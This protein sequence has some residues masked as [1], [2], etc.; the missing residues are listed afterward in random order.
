[1]TPAT[2]VAHSPP[3]VSPASRHGESGVSTRHS[4]GNHRT[5]IAGWVQ[6][7]SHMAA[8]CAEPAITTP[9]HRTASRTQDRR[10]P[11]TSALAAALTYGSPRSTGGGAVAAVIPAGLAA[12]PG[13]SVMQPAPASWRGC[14]HHSAGVA[15]LD[16]VVGA[17]LT[18][19]SPRS[20]P[21]RPTPPVQDRREPHTTVAGAALVYGSPRSPR[22][23][24]PTPANRPPRLRASWPLLRRADDHDPARWR[25]CAFA[26]DR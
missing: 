5:L 6:I 15:E 20:P 25:A 21:R 2:I 22:A 4:S 19:G 17:A 3:A 14:E 12:L 9:H 11:H 24:P 10:Q 26:A 7:R 16:P 18:C 8:F 23:A 1:M 13:T